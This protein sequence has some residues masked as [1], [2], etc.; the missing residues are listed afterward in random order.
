MML[1]ERHLLNMQLLISD[2]FGSVILVKKTIIRNWHERL[3]NKF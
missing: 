2:M 3:L 1:V